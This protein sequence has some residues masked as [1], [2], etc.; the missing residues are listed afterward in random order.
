MLLAVLPQTASK[1]NGDC[2]F[3]ENMC[4]WTNPNAYSKLDDF[5][6]LRQFSLGNFE[7]KYDHTKRSS[8]GS[9]TERKTLFEAN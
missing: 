3:D 8:E 2:T 7:P 9:T 4:S 5:D 6:W 1:G